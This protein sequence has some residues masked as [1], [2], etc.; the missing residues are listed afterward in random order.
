MKRRVHMYI[1]LCTLWILIRL[2]SSF[3]CI[4]NNQRPL[5]SS[6]PSPLHWPVFHRGSDVSSTSSHHSNYPAQL[7]LPQF[8]RANDNRD[9]AS[10]FPELDSR[11]TCGA[12]V[13]VSRGCMAE[14]V[15]NP[16][17]GGSTGEGMAMEAEA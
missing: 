1:C 11:E 6:Y 8:N 12:N 15:G 13:S 16:C 7:C 5:S 9:L 17:G 3:L 2:Y 14:F 10:P 4:D